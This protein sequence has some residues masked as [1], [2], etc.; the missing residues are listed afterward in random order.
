M[1]AQGPVTLTLPLTKGKHQQMP[2]GQVAIAYDEPWPKKHLH[3]LQAAYARAPWYEHYLP[4]LIDL[5]ANPGP[6]LLAFNLATMALVRKWTGI[7]HDYTLTDNY[8]PTRP[9]TIDLRNQ[10]YLR[11]KMPWPDTCRY[12]HVFADRV[13]FAPNLSIL[14]AIFCLGPDVD[15]LLECI[16]WGSPGPLFS[17]IFG[18]K[19]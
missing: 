1:T 5:Y 3:T 10:L 14:D 16:Y 18:T 9:D 19:E 6:T 7:A 17:N 4:D 13:P 15:W 11:K 2:I 12:D 8:A